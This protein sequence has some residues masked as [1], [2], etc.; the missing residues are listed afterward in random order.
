MPDTPHVIA[1]LLNVEA[2]GRTRTLILC[3]V[4]SLKLQASK[5]EEL[6]L[7][8]RV[9]AVYVGRVTADL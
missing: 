5:V 3:R 4:P 1:G 2:V 8:A 9:N 7:V 6:M